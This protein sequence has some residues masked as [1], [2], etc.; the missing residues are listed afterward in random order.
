MTWFTQSQLD[1]Q[2]PP[3]WRIIAEGA[4]VLA[5]DEENGG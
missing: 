1:H 5:E 4:K 2:R 3:R